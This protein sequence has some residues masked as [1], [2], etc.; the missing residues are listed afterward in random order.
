MPKKQNT[1]AD[2]NEIEHPI[3]IVHKLYDLT[4]ERSDICTDRTWCFFNKLIFQDLT[5][6]TLRGMTLMQMSSQTNR[7]SPICHGLLHCLDTL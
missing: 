1:E 6:V 2:T 7:L 4:D 5:P 3:E